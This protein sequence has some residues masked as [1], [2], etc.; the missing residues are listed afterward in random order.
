MR[1]IISMLNRK[2]TKGNGAKLH[3][4]GVTKVLML[5]APDW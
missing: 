5:N 2:N 1:K 3:H 4:S